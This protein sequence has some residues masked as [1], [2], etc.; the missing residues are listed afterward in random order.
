MYSPLQASGRN[1]YDIRKT[2][3]RDEDKDGPLCYK[4]L[5]WIETYLNKPEVK[6]QLG[7]P[8]ELNFASC[9]MEVNRNFLMVSV[10]GRASTRESFCERRCV[11]RARQKGRYLARWIRMLMPCTPVLVNATPDR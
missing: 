11:C 2:C 7:A 6:E 9:N 10:R 4:E 1:L 3:N 8:K 5:G